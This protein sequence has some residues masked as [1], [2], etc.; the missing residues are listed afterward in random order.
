MPLRTFYVS[1]RRLWTS[2][3]YN[4]N[5]TKSQAFAFHHTHTF[6]RRDIC[7]RRR[8]KVEHYFLTDDSLAR[9]SKTVLAECWVFNVTE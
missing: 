4:G 8:Q 1:Y 9:M 3:C 2:C 7:P 6:A 5:L